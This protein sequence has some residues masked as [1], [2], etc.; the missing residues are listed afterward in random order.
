VERAKVRAVLNSVEHVDKAPAAVYHELLDQ[1]V[2]LASVSTMYRILRDHDEVHERRRQA[3]HPARV[4]PELVATQPNQVWSWDITKLHGP[5]KWTYYYLYV[6][7]DIYSR[8]VVGWLIAERESAARGVVFVDELD[9]VPA[10]TTVVFSAHGVS[11]A[12]RD[13]ADRRGLLAIDATCPLV[14]KVHAEARRAATRGDTIIL[15]GHVGHEEVE[16][17]FGETPSQ[18]V[19]VDTAA[20]IAA[21]NVPDAARVSYLTQ[22]TLALDETAATIQALNDRF[23]A[24][25]GPGAEDICY[26]TTNRQQAVAAVAADSDL[27]LVV[28]SANSSNSVRLVELSRRLGTAAYLIDDVTCIRP[29]WLEEARVIGLSAGASAPHYLVEE[30]IDH[31]ASLGP[32]EVAEHRVATETIR[33]GLPTVVRIDHATGA[34][35]PAQAMQP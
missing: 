15:I 16:G 20:D 28:G 2:Y 31:L 35:T 34:A 6:I 9:E 25:T 5:A 19:V 10:G 12:V 30:V 32:I 18:T 26:A 8:Y 21:L 7:I 13:D 22:T 17:T 23:P 1:G 29:E 3:V 24:A 11:P 4:K 33:F 27:L 14:A